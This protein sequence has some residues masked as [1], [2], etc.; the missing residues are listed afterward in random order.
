MH[1]GKKACVLFRPHYI[2]PYRRV[3]LYL[4]VWH[5]VPRLASRRQLNNRDEAILK[6]VFL[7]HPTVNNAALDCVNNNMDIRRQPSTA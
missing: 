7:N 5:Y 3:G 2:A 4:A 6:L 1:A